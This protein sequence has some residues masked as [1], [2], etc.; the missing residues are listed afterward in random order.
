VPFFIVLAAF[1]SW[2]YCPDEIFFRKLGFRLPESAIISEFSYTFFTEESLRVKITFKKEDYWRVNESI[3]SKLN[4][5]EKY[6]TWISRSWWDVNDD[7]IIILSAHAFFK[8][9]KAMTKETFAFVTRNENEEYFLYVM[10]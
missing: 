8:G 9:K 3:S 10:Q 6:K 7:E 2:F 5:D 4:V 1:F